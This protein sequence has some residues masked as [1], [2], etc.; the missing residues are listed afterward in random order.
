MKIAKKVLSFLLAAV[1]LAGM[2]TAFVGAYSIPTLGMSGT[3]EGIPADAENLQYLS[4]LYNTHVVDQVNNKV[5]LDT[6]YHG[7]LYVF[8][9]GQRRVLKTGGTG[10]DA[11]GNRTLENGVT[12]NKDEIALGYNGIQFEKGLGVHPSVPGD[13]DRYI[14]YD[15]SKLDVNY[16]YAVVGGTGEKITIPNEKNHYLEFEVLGSTAET[17]DAES[18]E[19]LAKVENIRSY[20]M[21]EFNVNIEGYNFIKLVIRATGT[22]NQSCGGAWA[23]ACVYKGAVPVGFTASSD[24]T[25]IGVPAEY[26]GNSASL[27][28]LPVVS[29]NN[30]SNKPSTI[31]AP[32]G[33]PDGI[34]TIGDLN[35]MFWSGIGMH[36]KA[37]GVDESY[38][39]FDISDIN[40]NRFYSAVGITNAN[41]K[42]GS[43][44]GVV[45]AVYGDYGD[46]NYV[47]LSKSTVISKTESGEFDV[48]ITG[49]KNLKLSVFSGGSSNASSGC[50]WADATLYGT[51][52]ELNLPT[53]PETEPT[54]AAT[55]KPTTAKPSTSTTTAPTTASDAETSADF[56]I[57]IVIGIV[58]AVVVAV[59]VVIIVL[60]SK[61]KAD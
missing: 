2:T 45:F 21:A 36:P 53:E 19:S 57:G 47:L 41:G 26:L 16:F 49:V 13:P 38:T 32:Y 22:N 34:I 27:S 25:Y 7:Y 17:Y 15:V 9:N 5:T 1:L 55:T 23:D 43:G 50:A 52:G 24:G 37:G 30:N 10:V 6:N 40:A 42:N 48:D 31:N 3:L 4:D 46:G 60:K 61:K 20:L 8:A 29:S 35:K 39:I 28:D 18:F 56:P 44:S 14:V 51:E 59:V 12:Y 11:N 33:E 58:A 54:E